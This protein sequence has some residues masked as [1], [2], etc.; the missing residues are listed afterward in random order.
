MMRPLN[1]PRGVAYI[2]CQGHI[3]LTDVVED[4][5]HR[6]DFFNTD[7]RN[8]LINNYM[9]KISPISLKKGG[10]YLITD[11]MFMSYFGRV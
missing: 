2:F 7:I 1:I 6:P 8:E 10:A 5:Q 11:V 9:T 3:S 4:N